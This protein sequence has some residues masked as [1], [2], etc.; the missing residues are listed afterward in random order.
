MSATTPTER[1]P[2]PN[3]SDCDH[4]TALL[5]RVFPNGPS[6]ALRD[7]LVEHLYCLPRNMRNSAITAFAEEVRTA[8][9]RE[10]Q[11][12]LQRDLAA[13]LQRCYVGGGTREVLTDLSIG[14]WLHLVLGKAP[15]DGNWLALLMNAIGSAAE[16]VA[17]GADAAVATILGQHTITQPLPADQTKLEKWIASYETTVSMAL[18]RGFL[19]GRR[20]FEDARALGISEELAAFLAATTATHASTPAFD[21]LALLASSLEQRH[22]DELTQDQSAFVASLVDERKLAPANAHSVYEDVLCD[23]SAIV[24][25]RY[26]ELPLVAYQEQVVHA[27]TVVTNHRKRKLATMQ[28]LH[29][30]QL[31]LQ[32]SKRGRSSK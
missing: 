27:R 13:W 20:T 31:H 32:S 14:I 5:L 16:F 26:P 2:D 28:Q 15:A 10:G 3:T 17:L 25:T 9:T 22:V 30:S 6:D 18:T 8:Y 4:A 23:A 21:E 1:L 19:A 29:A 24:R 12:R 7:H 11:K